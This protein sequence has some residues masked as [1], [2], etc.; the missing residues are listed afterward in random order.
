[1]LVPKH[2]DQAR[3]EP[4]EAQMLHGKEAHL[5]QVLVSGNQ[6]KPKETMQS[7][8]GNQNKLHFEGNLR[9]PGALERDQAD[10][11]SLAVDPKVASKG[12]FYDDSALKRKVSETFCGLV[13]KGTYLP[14]E[15][16][17]RC[18]QVALPLK[19]PSMMVGNTEGG[20]SK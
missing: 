19:C 2:E 12:N 9:K 8:R 7:C 6:T 3:L 18:D 14:N 15:E 20:K 16:G 5:Q 11:G 10:S 4:R 17:H 13:G 1:M